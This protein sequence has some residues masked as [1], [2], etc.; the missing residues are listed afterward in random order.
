MEFQL[1]GRT[2][3]TGA[4]T[5]SHDRDPDEESEMSHMFD[6]GNDEPP[7]PEET[8]FTDVKHKAQYESWDVLIRACQDAVER[9]ERTGSLTSDEFARL[10]D[11]PSRTGGR[12]IDGEDFKNYF[13]TVLCPTLE[14]HPDVRWNECWK[15]DPSEALTD[16]EF[17]TVT[18]GFNIQPSSSRSDA[19][20]HYPRTINCMYQK[21]RQT[22]EGNTPRH[23]VSEYELLRSGVQISDS[24]LE[25][26]L[27][28][29]HGQR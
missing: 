2:F 22:C 26:C 6:D 21:L 10:G 1:F 18:S 8:P 17:E 28:Y 25:A 24:H 12:Q 29:S 16:E 27:G 5:E 3:S 13:W 15:F 19:R 9:L 20:R 11:P 4:D 23:G 7:S 14:T